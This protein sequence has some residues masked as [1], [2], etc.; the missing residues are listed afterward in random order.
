MWYHTVLFVWFFT[1]YNILSPFTWLQQAVSHYFS[2]WVL[3]N[4]VCVCVY[5]YTCHIL[6]Y[7]S[8][9][10]QS[11]LF[12]CLSPDCYEHWGTTAQFSSVTETCLTLWDSMEC[13]TPDFLVHC[14]LPDTTQSHV[15]CDG[16]AIQPTHPL[17]SPSPTFNFSQHQGLSNESVLLIM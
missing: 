16:D 1:K 4:C 14:Q 11:W 15:H 2:V 8:A 5:I 17:Q 7:V 13:R 12:I 10:W 3:F 9:D 6:R